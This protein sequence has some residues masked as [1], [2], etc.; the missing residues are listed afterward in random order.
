MTTKGTNLQKAGVKRMN[1]KVVVAQMFQYW[2]F[3]NLRGMSEMLRKKELR[4]DGISVDRN[5]K[6]G[7]GKGEEEG[8]I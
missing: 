5:Q 7:K 8:Y 2:L 6:K 4:Q 3:A 1:F